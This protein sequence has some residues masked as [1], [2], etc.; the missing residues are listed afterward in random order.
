MTA[1]D[2]RRLDDGAELTADVAVVGAGPA[3]IVTALTLA[4]AGH[5]VALIESGATRFDPATQRLG[6]TVGDDPHHV[7][8]DLA[9][10][11]AI[12]GA[13]N[14]WGGRCIPF[15][16]VDF[17][18][19]EIT[20][21][22]RWPVSYEELARFFQ[23]ACDWCV[24]GRALFDVRDIPTLAHRAIVPGFVDGAVRATALERSSLPTNFGSHYLRR[25]K[26]SKNLT[27]MTGL[28]CTEIACQEPGRVDH[29][30][31]STLE[32]RCVTIRASKYV[33]ACGGVETTRLLFAS[34][35]LD[36]SGLGNHSGHLGRWYMAHVETRVAEVHF[37]TPPE[38]TVYGHERDLD[39]V[40]VRRRFTL[41]NEVQRQQSLPNLSLWLVNPKL[42]DPR[43]RS[44][45]LSFAYLMLASP[46]GRFFIAEGIRQAHVEASGHVSIWRHVANV[47]RNPLA[48]ARFAVSFGYQRYL[49]RGRKVPGFFVRSAS[50]VYP[51]VYH[52][53]HVPSFDSYVKPATAVDRVGMPRLETRLQFSDVDIASVR[54]A[55]TILDQELRNQ[56]LGYVNF[57]HEDVEAAV[58]AQLFGGYHQAGTTRMSEHP[59]E[60]VVDRNLA[61]HGFDDLFIAS[62][63]TFVTSGQANSTFLLIT[64]AVRLADHLHRELGA[65]PKALAITAE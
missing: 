11:R 64:L 36:P 6:N 26:R 9:T 14:L 31:T 10:R 53:E 18:T 1:L 34:N 51:L 33:I 22:V 57:L 23:S 2:G 50:N 20:G 55:H 21:G 47:L 4:D 15:D 62:S 13:S 28:T 5:V 48:A 16:P 56:G 12:G 65:R 8:M 63:S 54:Q 49:R 29:L 46:V 37:S 30:R 61:V 58:R 42:A 45:I 40:Y 41:S 43:H 3:G 59:E 39:G 32:G 7:S 17:E 60:G 27:L 19:R 24:C 35:R 52:G 25:L 44:A 38:E